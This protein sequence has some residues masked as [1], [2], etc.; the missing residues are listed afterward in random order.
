MT[1]PYIDNQR[2]ECPPPKGTGKR[3]C[4]E[5]S[6]RA[7][8]EET[9]TAVKEAVKIMTINL[10][11]MSGKS[12]EVVETMERRKVDIA[13]EIGGGFK[14]FYSKMTNKRNGVGIIFKKDWL[15]NMLEVKRGS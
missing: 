3:D 4:C 15:E 12:R 6:T 14:L 11:T 8:A 5:G 9:A 10:G 2:K 1:V 13:I 7:T